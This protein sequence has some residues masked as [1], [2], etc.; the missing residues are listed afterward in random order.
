MTGVAKTAAALGAAATVLI[1]LSAVTATADPSP[2]QSAGSWLAHEVGAEGVLN[3]D[4][5]TADWGL[6][7]DALMA[8]K[9][10]GA[11]DA[12]AAKIT[13]ALKARA[14]EYFTL[15]LWS[16][17]GQRVAGAT[18]KV[19]YA[20][21]IAGED[22]A[23]YGKFDIESELRGLMR[24]TGLENGRFRDKM[25][26]DKE[27]GNA[28]D[29]SLAV[30][31]LS[32]TKSGVPQ[33]AVDFLIDQQCAAGGFRLYP[34]HN[35][36]QSVLDDCDGQG[37]ATLDPDSTSMAVQSLL[38]ADANGKTGA[39][40]A[41]LK[42]AEWL[43]TQQKPNG[44]FA[45][46]GWTADVQNTNSTGLAGQAL[47]ATGSA[48]ASAKAAAW[49]KTMQLTAANGGSAKGDAG[50]IAYSEEA[51]KDAVDNGFP[52]S[53]DQFRRATAQAVLGLTTVSLGELGKDSGPGPQPSDPSSSSA[54]PST[55]TSASPS[56]PASSSQ[57]STASPGVPGTKPGGNL[58]T[59]G[60]SLPLF[61]GAAALLLVFGVAFVVLARRRARR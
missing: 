38:A 20:A 23:K 36:E 19:A 22:P 28:F 7:I 52:M 10:T 26:A 27:G 57:S 2:A 14:D 42:G 48:D 8:L 50:A 18:A 58:P 54:S 16:D 24:T 60:A 6:T 12:T 3:T 59:T 13:G 4:F 32:R 56:S 53:R 55:S 39:K 21:V 25:T 49:V 11:D 29:Q 37:N 40:A 15:D 30:L 1:G 47:L 44:S 35:A 41:A 17:K 9:A 34:F 61:G 45:G 43:K 46:S 33:A 31:A 5:G 51:R